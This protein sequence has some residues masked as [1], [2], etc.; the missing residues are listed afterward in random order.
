MIYSAIK[1]NNSHGTVGDFLKE[2]ITSNSEV[3]IVSVYFKI[4]AYN[5]LK[6]LFEEPVSIKSLAQNK[7][8]FS[9]RPKNRTQINIAYQT[10]E[11]TV[12]ENGKFYE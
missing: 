11:I 4:Y 1:V 10:S 3:S 6:F 8:N 12:N 5:K 2:V 9:A 7:V